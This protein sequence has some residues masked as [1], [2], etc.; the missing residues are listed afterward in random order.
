MKTNRY[1]L[2]LLLG[3]SLATS[4]WACDEPK[5]GTTGTPD[6]GNDDAGMVVVPTDCTTDPDTG[7]A[8]FTLTHLGLPNGA[9][10]NLDGINNASAPAGM[11]STVAG[12]GKVDI[13]GGVDNALAGIATSLMSVIDLNMALQNTL[14]HSLPDGGTAGSITVTVALSRLAAGTP[15][16]DAS[17]CG[18]ITVATAGAAPQMFDANGVIAN[19]SLYLRFPSEV[20]FNIGLE[21]PPSSCGAG[22]CGTG[23]LRIGVKSAQARLTLNAAHT[24]I[25]ASS[26]LG[27]FIFFQDCTGGTLNG[28]GSCTGGSYATQNTTGF[29]AA[30]S[31]FAT[32]VNLAPTFKTMAIQAF[33]GAR[34]LHMNA[35]GT[36]GVCSGPNTGSVDKNSVSVALA[37]DSL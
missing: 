1:F 28:D 19:N 11:G 18:T 9:G 10:F 31:T 35:D 36:L 12:C 26:L 13:A 24:A 7:T 22:G 30:L 2:G 16:N 6:A 17:V 37:I 14:V 32:Q 3:G 27:G 34:D 23:T 33:A 5:T 29:Q 8:Q 4:A 21:V 25:Q 15:A 20:V